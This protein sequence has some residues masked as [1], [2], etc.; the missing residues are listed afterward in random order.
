[1]QQRLLITAEPMEIKKERRYKG[2]TVL[3]YTIQYPRFEGNEFQTTLEKLNQYYHENAMA[4][5]NY[6]DQEL[7]K[8]AVAQYEQAQAQI[9][10]FPMPPYEAMQTFTLQYA[11]EC[12]LSLY[13]DRYEYL[14]GAHG[15]TVRSAD[16]WSLSFGK[17]SDLKA[18]F[19]FMKQPEAYILEEINRQIAENA[20]QYFPSYTKLTDEYFNPDSFY[21]TAK[22]IVVFYQLYE[23]APYVM[24]IP[25]FTINYEKGYATPPRCWGLYL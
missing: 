22:G 15:N 3:I 20:D 6:C 25:S 21:V 11:Q 17:R 10:R 9:N 24:G 16:T 2:M 12:A 19:P 18:F 7:Y 14:G 5:A 23:I 4:Y 1:M 8:N 13:F